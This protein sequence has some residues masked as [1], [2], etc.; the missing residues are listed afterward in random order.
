M[1]GLKKPGALP[2]H[3]LPRKNEISTDIKY[4][5]TVRM[6]STDMTPS[7][8]KKIVRSVL[9]GIKQLR[10]ELHT[11]PEIGF[12]LQSTRETLLKAIKPSNLK[13]LPAYLDSGVVALLEGNH[14]GRN[15][16]LRTDMD[17][18]PIQ[19]TS[20]ADWC[21][22]KSDFSHAC[23][24]DGHMA[25]LTGTIRVLEQLKDHI[26][27]S[28]RFVFQPA[29]EMGGGGKIMGEKGLL[30]LDPP[31][32]AVYALHAWTQLPTGVI[33]AI[34]G[35]MMAAAD[36]FTI[37]LRGPGGHGA[38]PHL[39]TDLI[40]L[41]AKIIQSLQTLTSRIID[42]LD[43][44]VVSV[45]SVQAGTASNI[46]PDTAVFKGTTRYFDQNLKNKI[47]GSI[48][49]II[50]GACEA[51]GAVYEYDYEEGYIPL[52]NDPDLVKFAGK[53]IKTY[54]GENAWYEDIRPSMGAEDFSF[55]LNKVPGVFF[56]L[57]VGDGSGPLHT[58]GFDFNDEAI[59]NGIVLLTSMTLETLNRQSS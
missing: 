36:T 20:G 31:A 19:D 44:V 11:N 17:A 32:S 27:G 10:H 30:E 34:P 57:G 55:Y 7:G 46:I 38:L 42:P 45:C 24:H 16:T 15:V 58:S 33:A 47:A 9:P 22:E 50:K 54:L 28:V 43:P 14:E 29:E 6:K 4:N 1:P 51:A 5:R 39:T 12:E 8:I 37:T 2:Q 23:G 59:E 18:L 3:S 52:V 25:I 41:G 48:E 49:G 13:I 21:S 26:P 40:V 53:T 56:F 35:P